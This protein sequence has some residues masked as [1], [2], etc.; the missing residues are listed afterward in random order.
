[1][2]GYIIQCKQTGRGLKKRVVRRNGRYWDNKNSEQ[3]DGGVY[4][5]ERQE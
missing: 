3:M 4:R 2:T 5:G 1:M